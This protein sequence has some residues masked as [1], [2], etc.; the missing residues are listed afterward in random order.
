MSSPVRVLEP[1]S[2]ASRGRNAKR[3]ILSDSEDAEERDPK[4]MKPLETADDQGKGQDTKDKKRRRKKKRKVP[5][6]ESAPESDA[7][8]PTSTVATKPTLSRVRSRSVTFSDTDGAVVASPSKMTRDNTRQPSAGPS[9][10]PELEGKLQSPIQDRDQTSPPPLAPPTTATATPSVHS[11]KGKG[12]ATPDAAALPNDSQ[13]LADLQKEVADKTSLVS[14]HENLVSSLQQSLSCQI[15][16]DLMHRPYALAPCGHSA[17]YQCLVNW[18][19]AP[20]PDVPPDEVVSVLHRKKTCPHCRAIVRDRPIEI[21]SLKEMVATLVKSGLATGFYNTAPDAPEGG[22]NADPWAGIFRVGG[23][24]HPVF[25]EAPPPGVPM[26]ELMGLHDEEDAVFRCVDCNHEIWDGVCSH[27]EREYPGHDGLGFD[28][29]DSSSDD[30]SDADF[31]FAHAAREGLRSLFRHLLHPMA[32]PGGHDHDHEDVGE[33][34]DHEWDGGGDTEIE[35]VDSDDDLG[36][37]EERARQRAVRRGPA[38]AHHNFLVDDSDGEGYESSFIDDADGPPAPDAA[39]EVDVLNLVD[40]DEP[41]HD[42]AQDG[43]QHEE[44]EGDGDDDDGDSVDIRPARL[45]GPFA[46]ARRRNAF[47]V[48]DDEDYHVE[49][50]SDRSHSHD[51]DDDGGEDL[52]DEVAAREFEMYGDDGSIPRGGREYASDDSDDEFY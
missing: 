48:S 29:D 35:S 22:A 21:W 27:C 46:L 41:H 17:C 26:H 14:E 2:A 44:D 23:Q 24:H 33:P 12:Q 8:S 9:S 10:M 20:P 18:F 49:G 5:V 42:Q 50:G 45:R 39:A 32:H 52:A 6:V 16:L 15:C 28:I 4:R 3:R 19:K 30:S 38:R 40:G 1:V 47:I 11:D 51:E 31:P 34:G 43:E 36:R 7:E 25:L 13:Q 37:L